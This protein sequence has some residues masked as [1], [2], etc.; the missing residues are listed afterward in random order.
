MERVVRQVVLRK[1]PA[2]EPQLKTALE[3]V[4]GEIDR[5]LAG[6]RIGPTADDKA[7]LVSD[8]PLLPTRRR[9]WERTLR[10]N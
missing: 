4:S 3:K 2:T 10:G 5:H 6:S 9:F 7:V 8:Y 1:K